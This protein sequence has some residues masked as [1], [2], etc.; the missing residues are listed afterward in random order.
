MIWFF[1]FS[2]MIPRLLGGVTGAEK[3]RG[4]GFLGVCAAGSGCGN[5]VE[6]IEDAPEWWEREQVPLEKM[7]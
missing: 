3:M 2:V 5:E 7:A 1:A 6:D 4:G